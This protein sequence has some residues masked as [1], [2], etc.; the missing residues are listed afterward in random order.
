M[1]FERALDL[2]GTNTIAG[3][4]DHIIGPAYKPEIP[5]LVFVGPVASDIPV[6]TNTIGG[7]F[8]IAPVFLKHP[9]RALRLNSNSNVALFVGRQFAAIVVDDAHVKAGRGSA[10]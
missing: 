9:R 10:H 4:D 2:K 5:I 6:A 8:G 3:T 7:R 1:L